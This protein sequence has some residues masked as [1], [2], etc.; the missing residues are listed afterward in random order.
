M[1]I[2]N[3]TKTLKCTINVEEKNINATIRNEIVRI[4]A[5]VEKFQ[6]GSSE[7]PSNYGRISWNGSVLTVS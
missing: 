5:K 3:E 7:I 2:S 4:S 6:T 1:N